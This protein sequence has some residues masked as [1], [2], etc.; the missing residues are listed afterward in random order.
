MSTHTTIAVYHCENST[1]LL[2]GGEKNVIIRLAKA[3]FARFTL[4]FPRQGEVMENIKEI[5]AKNLVELRKKNKQ[6]QQELADKLGY[7]GKAISRWE[8]A[9][10]L[11]DIEVLCQICD[12]YGVTFE[13]LLQKEQPT[14]RK[15]PY[16]K[17][18]D[19]A[20]RLSITLIA[21]CTVWIIALVSYIYLLLYMGKNNWTIFVW[22]VPITGVV[23]NICNK[24]WGNKTL[25][26]ITSSFIN[27]TGI[28]A[29]Y[30]QCLAAGYN[31]WLLFIIG[32][33]IQIII[34]LSATL[35]KKSRS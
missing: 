8:R 16:V 20:S 23:M 35:K 22:A 29:L 3:Q 19:T 1:F 31:I 30:L 11:P 17:E 13:Y 24:L 4:H 5:I 6:T 10:S 26:I 18:E 7:S 27:W 28:L 15:N 14:N 34:L 21:A 32:V 12:L 9:E 2:T 25:G 33:P